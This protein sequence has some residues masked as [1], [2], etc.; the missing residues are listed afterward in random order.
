MIDTPTDTQK[1]PWQEDFENCMNLLRPVYTGNLTAL[2]PGTHTEMHTMCYGTF[3]ELMLPLRVDIRKFY[4][5]RYIFTCIG[6]LRE[7]PSGIIENLPL[8]TT[9]ILHH[10]THYQP[11][12][13][14]QSIRESAKFACDQIPENHSVL[15]TEFMNATHEGNSIMRRYPDDRSWIADICTFYWG[16]PYEEFRKAW[17]QILLGYEN[18]GYNPVKFKKISANHLKQIRRYANT[19]GIWHTQYFREKFAERSVENI[20]RLYEELAPTLSD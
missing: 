6:L 16:L 9:A 14:R 20:D 1:P 10:K 8:V 3:I 13:M 7:I 11:L 12:K 18:V 4:N 5:L 19:E 2:N 15:L 17:G